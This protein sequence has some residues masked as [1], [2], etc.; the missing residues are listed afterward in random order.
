MKYSHRESGSIPD[1][2]SYIP[3]LGHSLLMPLIL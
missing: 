2:I 1:V 3:Y